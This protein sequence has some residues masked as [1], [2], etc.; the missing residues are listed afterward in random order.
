MK[1]DIIDNRKQ[2]EALKDLK[3]GDF[4][5]IGTVDNAFLVI[6]T[7]KKEVNI[8]ENVEVFSIISNSTYMYPDEMLVDTFDDA[9]I[10][11]II[12]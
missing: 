5:Y 1:V 12:N 6:N 3:P 4:F 10:E 7:L 8:K 9:K 2:P 11:L